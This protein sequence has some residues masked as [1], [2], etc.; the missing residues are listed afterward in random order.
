MPVTDDY[1]SKVKKLL[2]VFT[3][4]PAETSEEMRRKVVDRAAKPGGADCAA[5]GIPGEVKNYIDKVALHAYK[6]TDEDF[7]A[8]KRS[9]YSEDQ[10]FEIT[11]GAALGAGLVRLECGM[12]VLKGER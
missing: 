4:G 11:L 2:E 7:L 12:T 8:L 5:E 10:I 6:V 1:L 3:T 9:G